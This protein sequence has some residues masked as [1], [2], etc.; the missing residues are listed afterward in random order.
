MTCVGLPSPAQTRKQQSKATVAFAS[1]PSQDEL[2]LAYNDLR[3]RIDAVVQEAQSKGSLAI[4]LQGLGHLR[5]TL[6]SLVKLAAPAP[7]PPQ[8]TV[9]VDVSVNT[10]VQQIIAALGQNPS[11]EQLSR[12]EAMI[13]G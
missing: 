1:L 11:A 8:V 13:D 10:A 2:C 9:N 6:D 12:L 3:G 5:Q 4:A 7:L